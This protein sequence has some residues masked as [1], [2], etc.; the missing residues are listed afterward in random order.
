MAESEKLKVHTGGERAGRIFR[1]QQRGRVW[2]PSGGRQ[3][4]NASKHTKRM[5]LNR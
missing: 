5:T 3:T 1:G 2:N 4:I